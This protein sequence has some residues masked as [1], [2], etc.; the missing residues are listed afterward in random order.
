MGDFE[1]KRFTFGKWLRQQ[2]RTLDLTQEACTCSKA[3]TMPSDALAV[4]VPA[5]TFSCVFVV[6]SVGELVGMAVGGNGV[7]VD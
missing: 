6:P 1:S 3:P 4:D 5:R 2:R 7:C